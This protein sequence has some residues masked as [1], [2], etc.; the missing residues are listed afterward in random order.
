MTEKLFWHDPYQTK[1]KATV[2]EQFPVPD[3]HAVILNQTCF[4]ATSGGQPN[5]L[6]TLDS[7]SIKDVRIEDGRLL[8]I[9]TAPLPADTAEGVLDWQRRFDHMQQHTGQHILS[10]AFYR[11]FQAET[12]SFHLGEDFCSIELNQ[13]NLAEEQI[14]Q[15]EQ[16]T[17]DIIFGATPVTAFFVDPERAIDFP[18]RKQSDLTESLR[19][20]QIGDFDMSPCSGTHVKNAGEVG[21]VFI[22]G[23]EKLSQS[24]KITFLCG[25]R[26]HTKYKKDLAVLRNLSKTLTTSF[27]LLP[28]SIAKLQSQLKDL[29]KQNNRLKEDTLKAEVADLLKQSENWNGKHRLIRIWNRPYEE[30]R[31]LAQ[32]LSNEPRVIGIFASIMDKRA[33]FFKNPSVDVDLRPIFQSFLSKTGTKGGGPSHFMEAGGIQN[34]ADLESVLPA[35]F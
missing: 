12:A 18:L 24:M 1:F 27:E 20:I 29:R 23:Y 21:M 13:P 4:Y 17:N 26:V 11:L 5:D 22:Y 35:L 28:D 34:V 31:F 10:A 9:L 2:L 33:V 16:L 32:K 3:G 30:I 25:N 19:I 8:H 6:G 14:K 15:A 7:V